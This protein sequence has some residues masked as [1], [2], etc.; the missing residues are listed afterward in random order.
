MLPEAKDRMKLLQSAPLNSWVAFSEDETRIVAVGSN[1][2][3]AVEKSEAAGEYDPVILKTPPMW[4]P[5]FV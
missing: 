2:M 1:Y 4:A 5:L 3:E